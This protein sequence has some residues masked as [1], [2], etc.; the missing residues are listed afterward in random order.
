MVIK[1]LKLRNYRRFER[2]DLELP[3]NLIGVIG[4]NGVGKSTIVEA[5]GWALYGNKFNRGD[6]KDVRSQHLDAAAVC[7]VE[8]VFVYGGEEYRLERRLKGKSAVVEAVVWRAGNGDPEAVRDSGVTDFIEQLLRLDDVSFVASVFAQQKDL[9]R[10]SSMKPE[11]RRQAINR[12]IGIDRIDEA[13]QKVRDDKNLKSKEAEGMQ[14][15]LKD[16]AVL[17]ERLQQLRTEEEERATRLREA[18]EAAAQ[19]GR[20]LEEVKVRFEETSKLRDRHQGLELRL[21]RLQ[22]QR[23]EQERLLQRAQRELEEAEQAEAQRQALLPQIER[24]EAIKLRKEALDREQKRAL[25]LQSRRKERQYAQASLDKEKRALQEAQSGCDGLEAMEAELENFL[26]REKEAEQRLSA[27]REAA[28]KAYGETLSVENRGRELKEKIESIKH[29]GPDGECP[30]CTQRLGGRFEEV[31]QKQA[32]QLE[33]LRLEYRRL[34]AEEELLRRRVQTAEEDLA[35]LRREKEELGK[36]VRLAQEAKR[37]AGEIEQHARAFTEQVALI[38]AR[39]A[40]LGEPAYDAEEHEGLIRQLEELSELM[41]KT[42]RLEAVAARRASAME[43]IEAASRAMTALTQETEALKDEQRALNFDEAAYLALKNEV[44]EA[45]QRFNLAKDAAAAAARDHAVLRRDIE[46]AVKELEEQE[47]LRSRVASLQEEIRSLALLDELFGRFRLDLAGR[48]RPLIAHRASE[49]V[50]LTTRSRYSLLELDED[51]EIF[52]YDGNRRFPLRRFSGGEQDLV[53]LCLRIAVSQVV[54]ERHGGA[55]INMIVLDEIFGSQDVERRELI[56]SA[57]GMLSSQFR[58]IFVITHIEAVRDM[59]P[60]LIE[61]EA[62]DE[63]TSR[64]R[65]L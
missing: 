51:Y 48:V 2:L 45:V 13:R 29:L 19:R 52:M 32:A 50:A 21:G 1:S 36:R 28:T 65:M 49:L 25:E 16:T 7:S 40:E 44:D 63:F 31:M 17:E 15:A 33:E 12:F 38:D 30:V 47:R 34:K 41:Q 20:E 26:K 37:R 60:V 46:N 55:P 58:Q 27:L 6:K 62:A 39:I 59:L 35:T 43:S 23:E 61:V 18:E 57:L 8:M 3:E 9:A 54:A 64:V 24:Y 22:S 5:I 14:A 10:L 53:N 42:A 56:L 11:E 4:R